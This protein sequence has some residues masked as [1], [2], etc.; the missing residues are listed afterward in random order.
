MNFALSLYLNN[1]IDR[2]GYL[3]RHFFNIEFPRLN[4][5]HDVYSLQ[6]LSQIRQSCT[7]GSWV[8]IAVVKRLTLTV[9]TLQSL[10]GYWR[11]K[12]ASMRMWKL[13]L[14]SFVGGAPCA[15]DSREPF[16][17]ILL[18]FRFGLFLERVC[19]TDL[20][21]FLRVCMFFSKHW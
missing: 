7:T 21:R 19:M 15:G 3:R 18:L 11:C 6:E 10:F 5:S 16:Y 2:G 13:L 4:S 1:F 9:F 14:R 8:S 17:N 12:K 20:S